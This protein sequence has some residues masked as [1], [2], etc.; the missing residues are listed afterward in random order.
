[1]KLLKS[2]IIV[3]LNWMMCFA[4]NKTY[5]TFESVTIKVMSKQCVEYLHKL[6]VF[7]T[8][9]LIFLNMAPNSWHQ[10]SDDANS[11]ES[12]VAMGLK[13]LLK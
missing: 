6:C 13:I 1:M 4:M 8:I 2:F 12:L 9:S 3:F 5:V 7:K 11:G 10:M